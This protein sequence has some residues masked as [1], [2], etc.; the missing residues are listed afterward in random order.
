MLLDR[1]ARTISQVATR[2][3]TATTA[4]KAGRHRNSGATAS[5]D[6]R[7]PTAIAAG[8]LRPARPPAPGGPEPTGSPEPL[9]K[10]TGSGE[11][12]QTGAGESPEPFGSS[13]EYDGGGG[14]GRT[15]HAPD[16]ASLCRAR[17][18][19]LG[20]PSPAAVTS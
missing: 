14:N 10:L 1:T 16:A 19:A 7:S 4:T 20:R 17:Y 13:E 11:A 3:A 8:R 6:S 12:G 5:V 18:G 9:G 2:A 15:S